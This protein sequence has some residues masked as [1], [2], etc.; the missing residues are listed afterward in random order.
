MARL[1]N[2][3][4]RNPF[5]GLRP[6]RPDEE[7]LFFGRERQVDRMVAKLSVHRFLA[8]V[9][10]SG[11]GKS[12]LVNCGLQPA[13]H[14]G[15]MA[16]AGAKW[17]MATFRPGSDPIGALA[18]SL[19]KPGVLFD[20]PRKGM[21]T[22]RDLIETTLRLGSLGLVQMVERADLPEGTQLLIIADQF[23]ELFRYNADQDRAGDP[24]N[25]LDHLSFVRLLLE[26]A[27]QTAVPIYVVLTMRSDF[28]GDCVQFSG[29]P[30]AINEGQYLVPR[31]SRDQIRAA[32]TGPA[33]VGGG[34]IDPVLVTRLLNDVGDNPDQLS[35]LQHAM[36]RTWAHWKNERH[37]EGK[38]MLEDYLAIGTMKRALNE[39]AEKAYH[40]LDRPAQKLCEKVFKTLTDVG[41]DARGIRR[42]TRLD[43][44]SAVTGASIEQLGEV[45]AVFRKPSRSFLMPPEGETLAPDSD[46]DISHESLM[47][48]WK[49]LRNWAQEEAHSAKTFQDL[50]E[51]SEQ[52]AAEE[53]G[54]LREPE[55]GFALR[56]R[57]RVEPTPAWADLYGG[58]FAA[59]MDYLDDSYAVECHQLAKRKGRKR[60]NRLLIIGALIASLPAAAVGIVTQFVAAQEQYQASTALQEDLHYLTE[61]CSGQSSY[62]PARVERDTYL[63]DKPGSNPMKAIR[64]QC[65]GDPE[66]Q[67]FAPFLKFVQDGAISEASHLLKVMSA[68]QAI[69]ARQVLEL[70][71]DMQFSGI[72]AERVCLNVLFESLLD[73]NKAEAE[74]SDKKNRQD[75]ERCDY[76]PRDYVH[77]VHRSIHAHFAEVELALVTGGEWYYLKGFSSSIPTKRR[78]ETHTPHLPEWFWDRER[79]HSRISDEDDDTVWFYRRMEV[80]SRK[81]S[82]F[83]KL[84]EP[85]EPYIGVVLMLFAWPIWWFW[86]RRQDRQDIPSSVQVSTI[87]RSLATIFDIGIAGAVGLVVGGTVFA[88]PTLFGGELVLANTAFP[89]FVGSIAAYL[90]FVFCDAI[91]VRYRRSLGKAAFDLRPVYMVGKNRG[92]IGLLASARRNTV[93]LVALCVSAVLFVT[94]VGILNVDF[95]VGMGPSLM[96]FIYF[97]CLIGVVRMSVG[98]HRWRNNMEEDELLQT[99]PRRRVIGKRLIWISPAVILVLSLLSGLI[100]PV[101]ILILLVLLFVAWLIITWPFILTLVRGRDMLPTTVIDADSQESLLI[102]A[103]ER[104]RESH[105]PKARVDRGSVAAVSV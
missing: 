100:T 97:A 61:Y 30:E 3:R 14:R 26:A 79:D 101:L 48:L 20:R 29:L 10:G 38:L 74:T 63:S 99:I 41:T 59:A 33:H 56:W 36:N 54:H 55:L 13:L 88:T 105:M 34:V 67:P 19:A 23:E 75:W 89:V 25:D 12:S 57:D 1:Q 94:L 43:R 90:Y 7:H 52:F 73:R 32:I 81:V 44:L 2:R 62:L 15:Y 92:D 103:P 102:D 77:P 58:G 98:L 80:A 96:V 21:L 18:R 11:S 24:E 17:R 31:L 70:L 39:H 95:N 65:D 5:P 9:G 53:A 49:R 6:F 93:K 64:E 85:V 40:E 45:F 76:A 4:N 91:L 84:R 16:N 8:V 69:P 87:R 27:A 78:V 68:E 72:E 50:R 60:R 28:L 83:Q 22:T 51:R 47:R 46:I 86:R 42:M 82:L 104:Y 66:T 71:A 35:I 37:A